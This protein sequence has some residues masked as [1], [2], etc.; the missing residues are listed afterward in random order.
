MRVAVNTLAVIPGIT[1]SAETYTRCLVRSLLEVDTQNEYLLILRR[2]N[3][4]LFPDKGK[5]V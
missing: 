3:G 1:V 4:H 2:D 5:N